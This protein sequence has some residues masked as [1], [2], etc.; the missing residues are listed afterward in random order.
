MN[1]EEK[2]GKRQN[3]GEQNLLFSPFYNN[4]LLLCYV[5]I[6]LFRKYLLIRSPV[7]RCML[8]T[9]RLYH[10]RARVLQGSCPA[11]HLPGRSC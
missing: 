4:I 5:R 1:R 7:N 3:Q 8:L 2:S 6:S 9:H 10:V 11:V